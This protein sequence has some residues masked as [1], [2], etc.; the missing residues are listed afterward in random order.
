MNLS[1][2]LF[3]NVL[4]GGIATAFTTP[5]MEIREGSPPA[6]A[7]TVTQGSLICSV[8]LPD[9]GYFAAASG[10]IVALAGSWSG[11]SQINGTAGWF[12]IMNSADTGVGST[13]LPRIDGSISATDGAGD[14]WFD[15]T[16]IV[17]LDVITITAF[18]VGLARGVFGGTA[19]GSF[20]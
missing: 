15:N 19:S 7:D 17:V 6:D 12:R 3:N 8:D 5:V 20:S 10:G 16:T 18:S 9:T 1:T 14:L 2:G 13:T 4:D 11:T